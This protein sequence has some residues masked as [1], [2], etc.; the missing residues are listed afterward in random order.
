MRCVWG[1][2]RVDLEYQLAAVLVRAGSLMC[3]GSLDWIDRCSVRGRGTGQRQD[4]QL[5]ALFPIETFFSFVLLRTVG[6]EIVLP[7]LVAFQFLAGPLT[8][9]PPTASHLSTTLP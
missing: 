7:R 9:T 5:V 3:D 8:S 2:E 1:S 4:G 6:R